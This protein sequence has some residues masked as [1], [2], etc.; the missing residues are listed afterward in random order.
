MNNLVGEI[1][2]VLKMGGIPDVSN[3]EILDLCELLDKIGY[4]HKGYFSYKTEWLA[5]KDFKVTHCDVLYSFKVG[6]RI[7]QDLDEK[8]F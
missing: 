7:Y 6:D 2:F 3:V 1:E 8:Y 4:A 5:E